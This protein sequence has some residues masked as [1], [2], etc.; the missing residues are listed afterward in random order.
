ME[1]MWAG[2]FHKSLDCRADDFNS[3]IRQT[4]Y[5][6]LGRPCDNACVKRDHLCVGCGKDY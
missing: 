6:R 1:K 3:S 4:G 2:R 5:K